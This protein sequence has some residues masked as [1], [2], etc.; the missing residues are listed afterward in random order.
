MINTLYLE[1]EI[2][3][4]IRLKQMQNQDRL[5]TFKFGQDHHAALNQKNNQIK[6][7]MEMKQRLT[8]TYTSTSSF[9]WFPPKGLLTAKNVDEKQRKERE[10]VF[11]GNGFSFLKPST[12]MK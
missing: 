4:K 12:Q 9:F 11:P 7:E 10:N 5:G 8:E 2:D 6:I 1:K 3:N